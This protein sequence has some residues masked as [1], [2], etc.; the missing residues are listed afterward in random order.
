LN[1]H[2]IVLVTFIKLINN[3]PHD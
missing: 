3:N 1:K 2:K